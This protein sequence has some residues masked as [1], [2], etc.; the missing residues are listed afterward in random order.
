MLHVGLDLSR[1]RVDVCW[2]SSEGLHPAAD[3]LPGDRLGHRLHDRLRDR[4]NQP[5]LLA[6]EADRVRRLVPAREPVRRDRPTRATVQARPETFAL[7]IDGGC[8][9]GV[10]APAL[11]GGRHQRTKRRLGSQ[12]GAKVARIEL[13]RKLTEA[14][15][16]MLARNQPF[17]PFA[18]SRPGPRR[19]LGRSRIRPSKARSS[20]SARP[21]G[22]PGA[23]GSQPRAQGDD[24]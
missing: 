24:R 23:R 16:Y 14:V 1:K 18:R 7:G 8:D 17:K 15:W 22:R 5:V 13:A 19:L 3:E 10:L 21:I 6:G 2:I 12:R 4:R 9:R 11:Q 20:A